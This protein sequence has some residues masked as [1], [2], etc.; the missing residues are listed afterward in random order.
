MTKATLDKAKALVARQA[1]WLRLRDRTTGKII[2]YGVPG[3]KPNTFHLTNGKR[4]TC[5]GFDRR[6]ECSHMSAAL[7]YITQ[8]KA[9]AASAAATAA[10]MLD[11][12]TSFV[13]WLDAVDR[14]IQLQ[15]DVDDLFGPAEPTTYPPVTSERDADH[16]LVIKDAH[17]DRVLSVVSAIEDEPFGALNLDEV[18]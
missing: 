8:R 18:A 11:D 5:T 4:C 2:G 13:L 14:A 15:R 7:Q 10:A 6:G 16:N 3:T 12:D 17:T 9:E 1:E